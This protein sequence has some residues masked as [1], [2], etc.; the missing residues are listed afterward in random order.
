[1]E[2]LSPVLSA[3]RA[4]LAQPSRSWCEVSRSWLPAHSRRRAGGAQFQGRQHRSREHPVAD[5]QRSI[6]FYQK[7][8]ASPW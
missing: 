2:S 4:R 1:M 5:L 7:Y 8:S 6:D 3:F